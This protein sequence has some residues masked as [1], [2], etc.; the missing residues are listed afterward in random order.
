M[1]PDG[2][3]DPNLVNI[4]SVSIGSGDGAIIENFFT[5]DKGYV[6]GDLVNL[7]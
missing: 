6:K 2:H 7:Y 5:Y 3:H 4:S 1:G